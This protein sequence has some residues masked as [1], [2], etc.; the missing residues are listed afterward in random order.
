MKELQINHSQSD[1]ASEEPEAL[2]LKKLNDQHDPHLIRLLA[3]YSHGGRFHLVFPWAAGNLRDLWMKR[4]PAL[5]KG[6]RSAEP[7]RWISSQILGLARALEVIHYCHASTTNKEGIPGRD[8]DSSY[9]RHGDLKPENILWF[10]ESENVAPLW[11]HGVLKIADF[12]FAEFHRQQSKTVGKSA[13]SGFTDTYKA[14][15]YDTSEGISQKY[16]IWSF[17]CILMQFVVWYLHGWDGV[18]E[19]SKARADESQEAIRADNFF[20]L[21][22]IESDGKKAFKATVKPSVAKVIARNSL[23]SSLADKCDFRDSKA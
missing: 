18:D 12:G 19:F 20:Q 22:R 13:V 7:V 17:G 23:D 4:G 1:P 11:V 14:P 16:D 8:A 5:Q 2:A 9:G 6:H 15:E 3:T 21:G 10:E